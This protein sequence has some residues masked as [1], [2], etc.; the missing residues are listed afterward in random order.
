MPSSPPNSTVSLSSHAPAREAHT[1]DSC[2][3]MGTSHTATDAV[4]VGVVL[5][6]G[7]SRR[8]GR[9]KRTLS[10][11]GETLLQR[12]V[13]FLRG[14]FPMVGVSVR[15]ADQA[16]ADLPAG[17]VVVPDEAPGSPLAGLASVL[18]RFREPVFAMAADLVAPSHD[19]VLRVL[20]AFQ[21]VD[22]SL[23]VADDH[24]EPLHAVYGPECL[25]HM[26]QL[27][28]VGA[29]SILDLFPLVR[30]ARVPFTDPYAL[31]QRQHAG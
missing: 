12:N 27:L 17:V 7:E 6:G 15:S 24:L 10:L 8:M 26:Q 28:A 9:D 25:S 20:E 21:D 30:V 13:S 5:A 3:C 1:L 16:P 18:A 29:H 4:R 19:A 14:V 2:I 22:V 11:D 31:L 23:P